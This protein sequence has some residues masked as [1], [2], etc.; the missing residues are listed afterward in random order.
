MI[1]GATRKNNRMHIPRMKV[2]KLRQPNVRQVFARVAGCSIE[3]IDEVPVFETDNVESKWNAMKQA[4]QKA[5]EHLCGWTKG[6]PRHSETWWWNEEVP[7]AVEEKRRCYKI[8]HKTKQQVIGISI[9]RQDEM[10]GEVLLLH[11]KIQG[12]TLLVSWK[13]QQERMSTGLQS[14]WQNPGR[15]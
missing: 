11:R 10:Q 3:E 5:A 14:K 7:K 2:W 12:R 9:K 15:M 8:W 13:V 6:P 1:N 4:W